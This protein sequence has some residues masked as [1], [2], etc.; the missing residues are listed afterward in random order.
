MD[1]KFVLKARKELREDESRKKQALEHFR[2]WIKKHPYIK[3]IRQDDIFLLQFLRTKK[4]SMDLAFQSFEN[5]NLAQK[6]Y[7][8]WFD[9]VEKDFD[10][11]MD[12]YQNGYIYPLRDRDEEGRKVI[13]IQLS[14]LDPERFTS[15]DAIRLSAVVSTALLEEEETQIAGTATII[16]HEGMTMKQTSMFSVTDVIDFAD[17][18]KSSVGRH[19]K[20][21]VVNLPPFALFLLEAARSRLNDK[22]KKRITIARDMDDLKSHFDPLLLPKE[23]GGQYSEEEHKEYFEK[24]F[25]T[26]RPKLEEIKARVVDWNKVPGMKKSSESVGSFRKLEID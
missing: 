19:K 21:Y 11:M 24:Y 22:L 6:K 5:Y 12:L 7:A 17:C 23:Y 4:Y 2:E 13:F 18:I 9:I 16:D 8:K 25:K 20:L 10:K 3:Q 14:K 26:V 15:A 1:E